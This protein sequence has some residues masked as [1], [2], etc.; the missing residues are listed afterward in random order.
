MRSF[1]PGLLLLTACGTAAP[2][3]CGEG[4]PDG[5]EV[6]DGE[7]CWF[8]E[9][10]DRERQVGG[11]WTEETTKYGMYSTPTCDYFGA[12]ACPDANSFIV[13]SVPGSA[14]YVDGVLTLWEGTR[15]TVSAYDVVTQERVA[16]GEVTPWTQAPGCAR[17][18]YG[19]R[20]SFPC[21][22]RAYALA[23][24][25]MPSCMAD[26]ECDYCACRVNEITDDTAPDCVQP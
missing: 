20:A 8:G 13:T 12:T 7:S 5:C 19:D 18:W 22:E 26:A 9:I 15:F 6:R 25:A 1:L 24:E 11:R 14:F 21:M 4:A 3:P 10:P 2:P 16:F 23:M 17:R